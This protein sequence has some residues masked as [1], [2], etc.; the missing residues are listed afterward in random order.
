[1]LFC[2]SCTNVFIHYLNVHLHIEIRRNKST[3]WKNTIESSFISKYIIIHDTEIYQSLV[4]YEL[5]MK[6]L[7]SSNIVSNL[8]HWSIDKCIPMMLAWLSIN[9]RMSILVFPSYSQTV[10][11]VS[12][13][14]GNIR[15]ILHAVLFWIISWYAVENVIVLVS[16]PWHE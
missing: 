15:K 7:M 1:M 2:F 14:I 9:F 6:R 13:E 12:N 10:N 5:L 8:V 4:F 3:I 11:A 16:F